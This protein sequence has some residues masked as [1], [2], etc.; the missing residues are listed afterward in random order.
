MGCTPAV[1]L[2]YAVCSFAKVLQCLCIY[3]HDVLDAVSH[4]A[5]CH[6]AQQEEA[7]QLAQHPDR[8]AGHF[9]GIAE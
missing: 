5:G 9:G 7:R 4:L 1:R 3:F 2:Q 8:R 6:E